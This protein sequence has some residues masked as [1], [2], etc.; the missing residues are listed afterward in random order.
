MKNTKLFKFI[1]AF[2]L[3]AIVITAFAVVAFA[4]G[5]VTVS[6]EI[7]WDDDGNR[8]GIRPEAMTVT[9]YKNGTATESTATL[10][11]AGKWK[12]SF[13]ELAKYDDDVKNAYTVVFS[14][15]PEGYTASAGGYDLALTHAP[16]MITVSGTISWD[17][18]NDNDNVRPESVDVH[19]YAAGE[20]NPVASLEVSSSDD[21]EYSVDVYKY[22]EGVEVEYFVA[23]M[24]DE[25]EYSYEDG[26]TAYDFVGVYSPAKKDVIVKVYWDEDTLGSALRPTDAFKVMLTADGSDVE[27]LTLSSENGYTASVADLYL[28]HQKGYVTYELKGLPTVDGYRVAVENNTLSDEVEIIT[29]RIVRVELYD[30]WVGGVRVTEANKSDVLGDADKGA[31]VVY[32]SEKNILTLNNAHITKGITVSYQDS[33][34]L[35]DSCDEYIG[36]YAKND[37]RIDLIGENSITVAANGLDYVSGICVE[38]DLELYGYKLR[39][40]V[41]GT[42]AF[43]NDADAICVYGDLCVDGVDLDV[44]VGGA[45]G[46]VYGIYAKENIIILNSEINVSIIESLGVMFAI[47]ADDAVVLE[48]TSVV[49]TAEESD[50]SGRMAISAITDVE[51]TGCDIVI[52]LSNTT[53]TNYGICAYNGDVVITDSNVYLSIADM[54]SEYD[55]TNVRGIFAG[56]G[57]TIKGSEIVII[58]GDGAYEFNCGIV[59]S[60]DITIEDSIVRIDLGSNVYEGSGIRARLGNVYIKNSDISISIGE[61]NTNDDEGHFAYGIYAYGGDIDVK[62]SKIDIKIAKTY[63][64]DTLYVA[65]IRAT[66]VSIAIFDIKLGG[67][68]SIAD[69]EIYVDI[70]SASSDMR[71]YVM[72]IYSGETFV[73]KNS[74]ANINI[75]DVS[76]VGS[77]HNTAVHVLGSGG[78]VLLDGSDVD[79]T[80]GNTL[81]TQ[82]GVELLGVYTISGGITVVGG[83]ISVNT[84]IV[85]ALNGIAAHMG[86]ISDNDMIS[87]VGGAKIYIDLGGTNGAVNYIYGIAADVLSFNGSFVYVTVG[88][89]GGTPIGVLGYEGV[90]I[91]NTEMTIDCVMAVYTSNAIKLTNLQYFSNAQAY[92]SG[93]Q[94]FLLRASDP[95]KPVRLFNHNPAYTVLTDA[96]GNDSIVAYC[97]ICGAD[98]GHVILTAPDST[99]YTGEAIDVSIDNT[100]ITSDQLTVTYLKHGEADFAGLPTNIGTYT[101]VVTVK[102]SSISVTYTIVERDYSAEIDD[103]TGTLEDL[104]GEIDGAEQG[105]QENVESIEALKEALAAANEIIESLNATVNGGAETLGLTEKVAAL[106]ALMG[107]ATEGI[108][109]RL[110]AL[111]SKLEE[112][113][114]DSGAIATNA[115]NIKKAEDAI[116][117]LQTALAGVSGNIEGLDT[118]LDALETLVSDADK[119]LQSDI[120]ALSAKLEAAIGG[121]TDATIKENADA[122]VTIQGEIEAAEQL[123]EALDAI[124]NGT[125]SSDGLVESVAA[126]REAVRNLEAGLIARI[127]ALEAQIAESAEDIDSVEAAI[128]ALEDAGYDAQISALKAAIEAAKN[129]QSIEKTESN[130][131]KDIYTITYADGSTDTFEVASNKGETAVVITAVVLGAISILGNV[132]LLC[133]IIISKKRK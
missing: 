70:D 39:V 6:G 67:N 84:G 100:L 34:R 44:E 69:S 60:S 31:T 5:T 8:D 14:E 20:A 40:N 36:V 23:V 33:S 56:T 45:V 26:E 131:G 51:I 59:A 132:A 87:I 71:T 97:T 50:T 112:L 2:V 103:I 10:N 130:G 96:S 123:I 17:D 12:Y 75:G 19:V 117:A 115:A 73:I 64:K 92:A 68:L 126:L 57:V 125:D 48:N 89:T 113:L 3:V 129:V 124:L 93:G 65:G 114:G 22:S 120:E 47:A 81:A 9:L 38:G 54:T 49:I 82:M 79:I 80:V 32:D 72:G 127:E 128:K 99:V 98:L 74:V 52:V 119:K 101:V 11:E 29:L 30:I 121:E 105:I 7:V 76:N 4:S 109:A 86:I 24:D 78:D 41:D 116:A 85:T 35:D 55:Y 104:M 77:V 102:G 62:N 58:T 21:W 42:H 88:S 15:T 13:A 16:E 37:I 83:E 118:R 66:T 95:T 94:I 53:Y 63:S 110:D 61:S 18:E 108:N 28:R 25:G 122:I 90:D 91:S 43:F 1:S 46:D 107:S 27:E 106:E 133:W 111:E